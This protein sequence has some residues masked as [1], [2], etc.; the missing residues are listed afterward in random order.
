MFIKSFE[1]FF[2][3]SKI[4]IWSDSILK[5]FQNKIKKQI[6]FK[7]HH[8]ILSFFPRP[9]FLQPLEDKTNKT[10]NNLNLLFSLINDDSRSIEFP[11]IAENG[12]YEWQSSRP[13]YL[14]IRPPSLEIDTCHSQ[15]VVALS[16]NKPYDKII[17]ITAKDRGFFVIKC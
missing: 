8:V 4:K 13:K 5:L 17:W 6:F 12:C 1:N 15:A 2:S 7:I 10:I 16:S 11:L 14:Q 9:S 3:T